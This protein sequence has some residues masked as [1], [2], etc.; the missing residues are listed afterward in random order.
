MLKNLRDSDRIVIDESDVVKVLNKINIRKAK[1]PDHIGGKVLKEC[2]YQLSQ[3][4]CHIFQTS[5]DSHIIPDIWLTSEIVPAPKI[6]L[7]TV[8]NDLRPIALTAIIMKSFE[9]IVN[10]FL[11]PQSLVDKNQYA[12]LEGRSVEDANLVLHHELQQHLDQPRTY[13]RLMFI[14]FSSAFNTIQ[15]HI[16]I[17]KLINMNVNSNL[18]LWINSFLTKRFQYVRFKDAISNKTNVKRS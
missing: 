4:L 5:M 14:D 1:G 18:I 13:A 6:H 16:M 15:P 2:R 9:M 10:R 17:E 12:Y 8:K 3:V 7:P 11:D